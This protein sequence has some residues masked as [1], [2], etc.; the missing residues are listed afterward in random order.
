MMTMNNYLHVLYSLIIMYSRI[1]SIILYHI[2]LLLFACNY[3]TAFVHSRGDLYLS[4]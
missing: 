4:R 2:M 1:K 3:V